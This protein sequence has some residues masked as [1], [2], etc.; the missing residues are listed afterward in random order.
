MRLIDADYL[1]TWFG[2]K[3]LYTYDYIIGIINDA[4]TIKPEAKLLAEVKLPKEELQE[5]VDEVEEKIRAEMEQPERKTGKW[6]RSGSCI[7]PYEC[8]RCGDTNE[9][10]TPFCPNCGADMRGNRMSDLEIAKK[11]ITENIEDAPCGLFD[12]RNFVGDYMENLYSS[13]GLNIDICYGYAYLE[14]FGLTDDEFLE[15][16]KYY[17]SLIKR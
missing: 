8:D 12:T 14:V 3:D 11:V 7:F 10:A 15:L 4:P 17:E 16:H 5:L 13:P 9:R 2:E 6:L 1:K